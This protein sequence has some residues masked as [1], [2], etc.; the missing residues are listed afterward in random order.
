MSEMLPGASLYGMKLRIHSQTSTV[1]PLKFGNWL[2]KVSALR[3]YEMRVL[4][5]YV[6]N[7]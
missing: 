2:Y 7:K 3:L 4:K 5:Y 6:E 1:S